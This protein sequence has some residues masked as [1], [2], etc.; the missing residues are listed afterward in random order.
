MKTYMKVN[1][2]QITVYGNS[3]MRKMIMP[4]AGPRKASFSTI[5]VICVVTNTV[6]L[7][8]IISSTGQI[9]IIDK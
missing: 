2:N 1:K 9:I 8:A 4:P 7:L 3:L 5:A 6:T